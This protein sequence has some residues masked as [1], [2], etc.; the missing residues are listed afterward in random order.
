MAQIM[1]LQPAES[2]PLRKAGGILA[3][4]DGWEILTRFLGED[5]PTG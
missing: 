3:L 5:K 2:P 4:T 1:L